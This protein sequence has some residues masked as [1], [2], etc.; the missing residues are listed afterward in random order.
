MP[1]GEAVTSGA[2][3][4][5][6]RPGEQG[7]AQCLRHLIESKASFLEEG[8]VTPLEVVNGGSDLA[9]SREVLGN[10]PGDFLVSRIGGEGAFEQVHRAQGL[11][12]LE[13]ERSK[14]QDDGA[15]LGSEGRS[16]VHGPGSIGFPGQKFATKEFERAAEVEVR[17][18]RRLLGEV[19]AHLIEIHP[20]SGVIDDTHDIVA[21]FHIGRVASG[22]Q[23]RFQRAP[24]GV[25]G[26]V[27]GIECGGQRH[28]RPEEVEQLVA[29]Q[30]MT[31]GG[32]QEEEHPSRLAPGPGAGHKLAVAKPDI[33]W[34][35]QAGPDGREAHVRQRHGHLALLLHGWFQSRPGN[36]AFLRGGRSTAHDREPLQ[37]DTPPSIL[38]YPG[39]SP[40]RLP[41]TAGWQS[42][43][44]TAR[45]ASVRIRVAA[46]PS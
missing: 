9:A 3:R 16:Q 20:E 37:G 10:G 41:Q 42:Q 18:G 4:Q 24:Q 44:P 17:R 40:N 21:Q 34:S 39:N 28:V 11:V 29:R 31:R 1:D 45:Y 30:V 26:L 33:G 35:K 12:C 2:N 25:Q 8:D 46:S 6:F 5:T 15:A 13:I 38:P 7:L 27:E 22:G 32:Q 36:R 19:P 23:V 43:V 14:S